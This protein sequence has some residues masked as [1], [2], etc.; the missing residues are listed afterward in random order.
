MIDLHCHLLPGIDDGA[1]SLGDALEMARIAV[2]DGIATTACTP[3]IYPGVYENSTERIELAISVLEA[4]LLVAG[5]PLKLTSGADAHLTRQ[6]LPRLA[7]GTAPTLGRSRYFLLE[8]PHHVAP[9]GFEEHVASFVAAGFVPV[10]T[11][12]E[13]LTWI[14]G[15]YA[16]FTRA[17]QCGAWLQV[18]SGSLTGDFGPDARYWAEKLLEEGWV[19]ILATDAH[20]VR[21]RRPEL[22]K[23]RAVAARMLG[24]DEARRLVVERPAAMLADSVPSDVAAPPALAGGTRAPARWW[25]R[26]M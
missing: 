21:G 11:H 2:A 17:A 9:P 4:E 19:H 5:I 24:K 15:H 10:I 20:G 6:L 16:M 14:E 25:S 3:H 18:T 22:A 12:P 8:P 7:D 23:G 26:L 13:R 1:K